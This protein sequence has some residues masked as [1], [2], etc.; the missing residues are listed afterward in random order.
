MFKND[1]V[2]EDFNMSWHGSVRPML[3]WQNSFE[4]KEIK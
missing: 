1:S 3:E 4:A 2:I